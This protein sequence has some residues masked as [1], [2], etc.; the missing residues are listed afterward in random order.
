M[1]EL[2]NDRAI[3]L[4]PVD[5]KEANAMIDQLKLAKLLDG[6]RGQ[7]SVDRAGLIDLIVI[8]SKLI[9]ELRTSISEVDLNPVIVTNS[10]C[11]IVDALVISR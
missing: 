1:I 8:F 3:K 6:I 4:A 5:H 11:S 2:L 9:H 10:G 7:A